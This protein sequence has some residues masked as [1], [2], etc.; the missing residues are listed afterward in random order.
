M[1]SLE[2]EFYPF[3]PKGED[4]IRTHGTLKNVRQISNLKPSTT[5]PPLL[6]NLFKKKTN[7][8]ILNILETTYNTP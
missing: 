3:T 5:R 1:Q 6:V 8:L 4:G 7:Y 2:P